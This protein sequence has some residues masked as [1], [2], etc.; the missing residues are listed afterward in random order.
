MLKERY[1]NCNVVGFVF[2][3]KL[4]NWLKVGIKDVEIL[5]DFFDFFEKIKVVSEII[6][7]FKVLDFVREN[8]K[9][10]LKLLV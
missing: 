10:F 1:G 8:V 7:S 9:I 4:E 3:N 6:F 2:L 5:R